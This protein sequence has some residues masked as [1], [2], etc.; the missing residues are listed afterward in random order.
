[1]SNLPTTWD[2]TFW[3]IGGVIVDLDSVGTIHRAFIESLLDTHSIDLTPKEAVKAWQTAV[4][5]YFREREGTEFRLA[6]DA[7]H[8]GV[9]SVL[10]ESIDRSMWRS[11]FDQ[12][13]NRHIE[14]K[15]NVIETL[16]S[17]RDRDVHLGIISDIDDREAKMVLAKFNLESVFDSVT[18]SEEVGRT[19]PADELF[20]TALQKASAMPARSLMVGDRYDHDIVGAAKAGMWTV[21]YGAES[22]EATNFHINDLTEIIAIV[23]GDYDLG[24]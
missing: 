20:E 15:P 12:A 8:H 9:E 5:R 2:A 6:A 3:D 14:V 18:T 11:S 7:Y 4:G 21:A 19:K 1:M 16:E 24:R 13:F 17:L 23:D 10:G 22:G